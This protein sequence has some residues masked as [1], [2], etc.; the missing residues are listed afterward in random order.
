MYGSEI[1]VCGGNVH[2]VDKPIPVKGS[3]SQPE[4]WEVYML[5]RSL[6][7]RVLASGTST[8]LKVLE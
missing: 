8:L 1:N 2:C 6:N 4:V 7:P 3:K 5:A